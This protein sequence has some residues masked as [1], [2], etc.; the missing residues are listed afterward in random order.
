M[1]ADVQYIPSETMRGQGTRN[2]VYG[3]YGKSWNIRE[4][5]NGNGNWLFTKKSDIL[6]NGVSCRNSVLNHYGKNRLTK[7]LADKLSKEIENGKL[8]VN[9]IIKQSH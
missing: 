3:Q 5:G 2:K 9:S 4:H 8:D 7:G 6:V 1:K